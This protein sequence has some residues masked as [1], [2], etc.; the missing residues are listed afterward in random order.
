MGAVAQIRDRLSPRLRL[1]G[2]ESVTLS[3]VIVRRKM[4]AEIESQTPADIERKRKP[5]TSARLFR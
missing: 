4:L 3:D 2:R 1:G 5:D